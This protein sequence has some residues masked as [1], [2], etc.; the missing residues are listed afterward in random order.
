M[1][2]C[3]KQPDLWAVS[4]ICQENKP[5]GKKKLLWSL[6][7]SHFVTH[8]IFKYILLKQPMSFYFCYFLSHNGFF[9]SNNLS[10]ELKL[11]W[12]SIAITD[13]E[14]ETKVQIFQDFIKNPS[15]MEYITQGLKNLEEHR[16]KGMFG[17]KHMDIRI[18]NTY[19]RILHFHEILNFWQGHLLLKSSFNDMRNSIKGN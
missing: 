18:L 14:M 10:D 11:L 17:Q 16:N 4:S 12:E 9:N 2:S 15:K 7:K 8:A 19:F 3:Y 13:G 1:N 5:F 6:W